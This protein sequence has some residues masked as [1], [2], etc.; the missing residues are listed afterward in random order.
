M[1]EKQKD[2]VL[3]VGIVVVV[4]AY[5]AELTRLA[6]YS[7]NFY[8]LRITSAEVI[9]TGGIFTGLVVAYLLRFVHIHRK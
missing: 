1:T 5:V 7:G 3:F 8:A 9:Y 6:I 2:L 4:G